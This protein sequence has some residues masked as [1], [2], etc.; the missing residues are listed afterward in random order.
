MYTIRSYTKHEQK[1]KLTVWSVAIIISSQSENIYKKTDNLFVHWK[2]F[3]KLLPKFIA[4]DTA[5][6][7]VR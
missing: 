4:A 3:M 7:D 5:T 6:V 1:W 2:L